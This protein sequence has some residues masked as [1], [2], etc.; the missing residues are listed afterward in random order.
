MVSIKLRNFLSPNL[1]PHIKESILCILNFKST[2]NLGSYLG[3]PFHTTIR[4][5]S[6]NHIIDRLN[7]KLASWNFKYLSLVRRKVLAKDVLESIFTHFM[8][9]AYILINI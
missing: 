8:Q 2:N 3:F 5:N 7:F 4:D 1:G 9:C 6:F